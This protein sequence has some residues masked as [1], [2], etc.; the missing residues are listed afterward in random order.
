MDRRQRGQVTAGAILIGL[1]LIFLAA[2][3][4]VHV[5]GLHRLWPVIL[6]VIGAIKFIIPDEDPRKGGGR[7]GGAWLIFV[8]VVFL[9]NNY[10]VMSIAQSWPLFIVAGGVSILLSRPRRTGEPQAREGER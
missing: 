7:T 3:T 6:L 2:Q 5:F 9:M 1:G 8:A 10:G 4:N